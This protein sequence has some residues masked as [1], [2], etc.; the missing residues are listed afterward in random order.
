MS[1]IDGSPEE[2]K[3]GEALA[4]LVDRVPFGSEAQRAEVRKAILVEHDLYREPAAPDDPH[5]AYVTEAETE[6][7]E[8]RAER[9]R[10]VA[11]KAARERDDELAALRAEVEAAKNGDGGQGAE[12]KPKAGAKSK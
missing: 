7:A 4:A 8:L 1:T 12:A 6:L 9:K 11:E 10:L 2:L 3:Y 5:A